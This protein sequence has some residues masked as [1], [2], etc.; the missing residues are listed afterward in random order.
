MWTYNSLFRAVAIAVCVVPLP[1]IAADPRP[2]DLF[3]TMEIASVAGVT[4]ERGQPDGPDRDMGEYPGAASWTCGWLVGERYF[5]AVVS[6]FRSAADATRAISSGAQILKSVPEGIQLSAV[7]GPGEQAWWGSSSEE[8]AIWVVRKGQT[9]LAVVL[10]G[11]M[12]RPESLREP[13][14]KLAASG[15]GKLP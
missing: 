1:A 13:L 14:R 6:R 12:K 2:C 7:P 4:P 8:G 5:A 3:S 10:A 11:E 15:I 9:V